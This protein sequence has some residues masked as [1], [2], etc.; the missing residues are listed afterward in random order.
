MNAHNK[1][2]SKQSITNTASVSSPPV[3][4]DQ[5]QESGYQSNTI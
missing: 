3:V 1:P 4:A 2:I 5:T